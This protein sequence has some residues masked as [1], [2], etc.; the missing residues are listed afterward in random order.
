[1]KNPHSDFYECVKVAS[2]LNVAENLSQKYGA[3]I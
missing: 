3:K 1:M 2:N